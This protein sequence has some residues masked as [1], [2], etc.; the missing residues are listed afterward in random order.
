MEA[1]LLY[2][3]G[4]NLRV[5]RRRAS[6]QERNEAPAAAIGPRAKVA[7]N[8]DSPIFSDVLMARREGPA[9]VG[10]RGIGARGFP[11]NLGD[12]TVSGGV[13]NDVAGTVEQRDN[14]CEVGR[15]ARSR[16]SE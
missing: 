10:E 13:G 14:R 8:S 5:A 12:L 3:W 1:S 15:T 6:V 4:R 2:E 9:G 16:S 7:G 11:R